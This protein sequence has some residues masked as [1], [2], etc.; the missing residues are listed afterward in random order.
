M[1]EIEQQFLNC[2]ETWYSSNFKSSMPDRNQQE[3]WCSSR[4]LWPFSDLCSFRFTFINHELLLLL[5]TKLLP[6]SVGLCSAVQNGTAL[7]A[8]PKKPRHFSVLFFKD[9][10]KGQR[11]KSK[12]HRQAPIFPFGLG[13]PPPLYILCLQACSWFSS[14]ALN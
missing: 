9:G 2:I 11:I 1:V 4:K 8:W 10:K 6:S 14:A 12:I 7:G 3:E 13:R 5:Q